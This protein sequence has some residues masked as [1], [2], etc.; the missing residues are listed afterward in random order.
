MS[1]YSKLNITNNNQ[2]ESTFMVDETPIYGSSRL[3]TQNRDQWLAKEEYDISSGNPVLISTN[4]YTDFE[5]IKDQYSGDKSYELTN[6]LGNVLAVVIRRRK[7]RYNCVT[8]HII[9][10]N[11]AIKLILFFNYCL[12]FICSKTFSISLSIYFCDNCTYL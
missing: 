9:A 2:V 8:N 12:D 10:K 11:Y 7:R 5:H 3:G 1:I 4:Y 6:H